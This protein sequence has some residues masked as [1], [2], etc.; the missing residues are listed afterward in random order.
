MNSHLVETVN[1]DSLY[2]HLTFPILEMTFSGLFTQ[3]VLDL[4]VDS[5]E[6]VIQSKADAM[7]IPLITLM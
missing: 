5:N 6:P 2:Y 7:K 4:F 1:K 3:L